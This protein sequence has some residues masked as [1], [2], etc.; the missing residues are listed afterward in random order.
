MHTLLLYINKNVC[1][2][3]VQNP[4]LELSNLTC[5]HYCVVD[6][7][8]AK[9]QCENGFALA[10]DNQT[11][12]GI[13]LSK[14]ILKYMQMIVIKTVPLNMCHE[15]NYFLKKMLERTVTL[16]NNFMPRDCSLYICDMLV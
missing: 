4:C 3:S 5:S 6:D 11:C 12:E 7:K 15:L 13:V 14:I 10:N 9:C 16:R 8:I 2:L 1:S